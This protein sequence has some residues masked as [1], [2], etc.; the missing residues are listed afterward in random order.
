MRSRPVR[1]FRHQRVMAKAQR[2][3]TFHGHVE[4][5]TLPPG[6]T[7]WLAGSCPESWWVT[8]VQAAACS[9]SKFS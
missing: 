5:S 3:G 9:C 7:R 4:C 6:G 8:L 1:S 2:L